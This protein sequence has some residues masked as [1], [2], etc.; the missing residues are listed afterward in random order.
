MRLKKAL[1]RALALALSFS[2]AA[3]ALAADTSF[4][5]V[6]P[7]AWYYN[8][9]TQCVS[10]GLMSGMG[11]GRFGP[12]EYM[13]VGQFLRVAV[14]A[15]YPDQVEAARV[16]GAPWWDPYYTVAV[17]NKLIK[18]FEYSRTEGDMNFPITRQEMALIVSR[19]TEANGEPRESVLPTEIPDYQSIDSPY[20][21]GVM[22]A[23]G[24]GILAGVDD[25]GTFLPNGVLTRG[26]A[27]VVILRMVDPSTRTKEP[28]SVQATVD[29][30]TGVQTWIEG[31][32]H[33]KAKAGDVVI[34]ADGT[35][36][37]LKE[38]VVT[39]NGFSRTILGLFQ[40]VDYVTGWGDMKVGAISP[41]GTPYVKDTLSDTVLTREEWKDFR[42]CD[43]NPNG[44]YVGNY[45]GEVH[46]TYWKWDAEAFGGIW[47]WI[48]P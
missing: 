24:K 15:V 14:S 5:D 8:D 10:R 42:S 4:T 34:K 23:Y 39:W 27:C 32:T 6:Q 9:V 45:N 16:A 19:V 3:P 38:T 37:T 18:T 47:A 44:K 7:G 13:T 1:S 20:R 33:N 29:P 35:R 28:P 43:L 26:A 21:S 46:N 40:N 36:V 22:I 31:Q 17:E 25:K 2:L 30:V 12:D 48:G 41:D 11:G